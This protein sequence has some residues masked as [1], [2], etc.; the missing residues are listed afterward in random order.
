MSYTKIEN[1]FLFFRENFYV[2]QGIDPKQH[3][4]SSNSCDGSVNLVMAKKYQK[5]KR[6]I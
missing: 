6:R 5:L 2:R 1:I 4:N 3:D